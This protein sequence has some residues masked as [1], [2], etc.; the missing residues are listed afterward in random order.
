LQRYQLQE[1]LC[2]YTFFYTIARVAI[3]L[4]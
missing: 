2:T 1:E 3:A 4:Q